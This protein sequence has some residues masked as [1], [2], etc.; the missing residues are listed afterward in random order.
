LED[1]SREEHL[2]D[3]VEASPDDLVWIVYYDHKHGVDIS[4]HRTHKG[5]ERWAVGLVNKYRNDFMDTGSDH[6]WSRMTNEQLLP[7]WPKV[8][9]DTEF[10]NIDRHLMNE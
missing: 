7:I 6:E 3:K 2:G 1:T 9:G 10:I 4:V 5:A 8:T